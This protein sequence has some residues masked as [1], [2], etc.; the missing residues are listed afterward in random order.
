MRSPQLNDTPIAWTELNFGGTEGGDSR[1]HGLPSLDQTNRAKVQQ[2]WTSAHQ[3][4]LKRVVS[5]A[6]LELGEWMKWVNAE[7][8]ADEANFLLFSMTAMTSTPASSLE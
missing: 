5:Q 8:A 4:L 2:G 6:A 7:A 1:P 3:E